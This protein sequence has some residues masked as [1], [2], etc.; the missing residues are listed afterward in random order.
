VSE[1]STDSKVATEVVDS[2]TGSVR[3]KTLLL[4]GGFVERPIGVEDS[5]LIVL[6]TVGVEEILRKEGELGG[7]PGVRGVHGA[8]D[9]AAETDSA[10]KVNN[11]L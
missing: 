7:V 3:R 5:V 9:D 2:V 10:M 8:E 6:R 11:E 4:E 1:G